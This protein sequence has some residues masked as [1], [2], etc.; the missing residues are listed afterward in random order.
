MD[1][2]KTN[3]ID[4]RVIKI[5]ALLLMTIDHLAVVFFSPIDGVVFRIIG[6]SAAPLFVFLLV[7]SFFYTRSRE[8][9]LIRLYVGSV[10]TSIV[11]VV[12]AYCFNIHYDSHFMIVLANLFM[13]LYLHEKYKISGYRR[14][15]LWIGYYGMQLL[16][17]ALILL[18]L[19]YIPSEF[20][21][22]LKALFLNVLL[23]DSF[24]L[25]FILLGVLFY[26]NHNNKKKCVFG[27]LMVGLSCIILINCGV[28]YRLIRGIY[29]SIYKVSPIMSE[30]FDGYVR[31]RALPIFANEMTIFQYQWLMIFAIPFLIL[32]RDRWIEQRK[33]RYLAY[34]Y[35]P[36]HYFVFYAIRFLFMR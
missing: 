21:I 13:I 34:V 20:L 27:C 12:I 32:Y 14:I 36:V 10:A 15:F 18:I 26:T 2:A 35:Y 22:L 19:N 4:S 1:W 7:Q 6:R 33:N 23:C 29:D 8:K 16:T 3:V 25:M 28:L 24:G 30:I 11:F 31:L 17:A 5:I 9:M